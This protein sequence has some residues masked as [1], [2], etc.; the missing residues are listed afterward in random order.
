MTKTEKLDRLATETS[1][2][3]VR[4]LAKGDGQKALDALLAAAEKIPGFVVTIAAWNESP[5]H[6]DLENLV[7]DVDD[8]VM[9][10]LR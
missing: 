1:D 6:D 3:C 10:R 4:I 2:V 5:E 7:G 8:E 9:Q